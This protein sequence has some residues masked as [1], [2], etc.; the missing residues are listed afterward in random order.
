MKKKLAV[1]VLSL[2]SL[3]VFL[4]SFTPADAQIRLQIGRSHR[5]WDRDRDRHRG[6]YQGRRMDYYTYNVNRPEYVR[7][8]YYVN[9]RRYVRWV[10]Y[11]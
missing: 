2:S 11:Y 10:R 7:Q 8:V 3:L 5:H 4:P 9:G 6:W 1:L